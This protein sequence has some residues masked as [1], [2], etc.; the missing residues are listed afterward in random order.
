MKR[1][2]ESDFARGAPLEFLDGRFKRALFLD[3]V[4]SGRVVAEYA[5]RPIIYDLPV[6]RIIDWQLRRRPSDQRVIDID[7]GR[8]VYLGSGG[9]HRDGGLQS[10]SAEYRDS[11]KAEPRDGSAERRP[12]PI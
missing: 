6:G 7:T 1:I 2:S 12:R 5:S 3:Q 4:C 11:V 8:C 9:S 10:R